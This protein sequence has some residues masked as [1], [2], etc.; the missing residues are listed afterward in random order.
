[1]LTFKVNDDCQY[2]YIWDIIG[3]DCS[4]HG[5]CNNNG[6]C[7]CD[8]GYS[9]VSDW[10]NMGSYDCHISYRSRMSAFLTVLI[11][12]LYCIV[13]SCCVIARQVITFDRKGFKEWWKKRR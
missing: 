10:I 3:S 6:T 1:M 7:T 4:G 5:V 12:S 11:L 13:L 2:S 9:G 8:D